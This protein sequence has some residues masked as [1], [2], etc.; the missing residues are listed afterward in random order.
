MITIYISGPITNNE[1]CQENFE[2]AQQFL[3][4]KGYYVLNPMRICPPSN[5]IFSHRREEAYARGKWNY[6]MRESIKAL[7][8]TDKIYMLKGWKDS[9]GAKLERMIA[10]GLDIPIMYEEDSKKESGE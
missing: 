5:L 9:K 7:A 4:S 8:T 6:Y 2:N 10:E 1:N 3:T